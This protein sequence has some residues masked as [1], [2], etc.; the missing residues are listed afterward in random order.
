M[1]ARNLARGARGDEGRNVFVHG[2]PPE[3]VVNALL[4]F[5]DAK[6]AAEGR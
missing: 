6:V 2:R 1:M 4:G 3:L 5:E